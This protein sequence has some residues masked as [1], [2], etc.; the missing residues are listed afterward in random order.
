M[1]FKQQVDESIADFIERFRKKAGKCLV[2]F[3]K[4][5]YAFMAI[6]GINPQLRDKFVRQAYHDLNELA[7]RAIRIEQFIQEKEKTW[8]S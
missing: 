2:Q 3:P 4:D 5:E 8:V 1:N 7:Y 6:S